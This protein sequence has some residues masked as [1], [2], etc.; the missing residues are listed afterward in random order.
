[1]DYIIL[2]EGQ[3]KTSIFQ[4]HLKPP[5]QTVS[6]YSVQLHG[7][8]CHDL[9]RF[10]LIWGKARR[11]E[12]KLIKKPPHAVVSNSIYSGV[13]KYCLRQTKDLAEQFQMA[14]SKISRATE[15][16]EK[17]K[18]VSSDAAVYR[19]K[20]LCHLTSIEYVPSTCWW[21]PSLLQ[22]ATLASYINLFQ[23]FTF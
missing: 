4:P 12:E 13:R 17:K 5:S 7:L 11:W 8:T 21:I 1:M 15:G 10:S 22:R 6:L 3:P 23:Y 9:D 19:I 2:R 16:K 14:R 18:K 20:V